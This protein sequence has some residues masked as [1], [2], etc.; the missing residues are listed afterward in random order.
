MFSVSNASYECVKIYIY[1]TD[2]A[3][4]CQT[5]LSGCIAGPVNG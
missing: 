5:E 3:L 2:E 4:W 1:S